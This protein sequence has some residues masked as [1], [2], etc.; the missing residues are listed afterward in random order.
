MVSSW[1]GDY[2]YPSLARIKQPGRAAAARLPASYAYFRE[3]E[4]VAGEHS[5]LLDDLNVDAHRSDPVATLV[6][7]R[8]ILEPGSPLRR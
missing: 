7:I 4:I 2:F 3:I 1:V 8:T 6:T 5:R